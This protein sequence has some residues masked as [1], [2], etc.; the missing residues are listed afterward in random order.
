MTRLNETQT[1]AL[2]EQT[3]TIIEQ[4]TEGKSTRE[5][6]ATIYVDNL[7]NKTYEQG[8]MM[9][10]AIIES[11]SAF[12]TQYSDAKS[13]VDKWLDKELD[14]ITENM[15]LSEKCT[16]WI[17]IS[18]AVSMANEELRA[19]GTFNNEN[20][21]N[22][23][24]N[25]EISQEQA[26]TE[27]EKELYE[28][29]KEAIQNSN[30]ML[31]IIAE[32]GESLKNAEN[33]NSVAELLLDFGSR[34]IDFRA[35]ASMVAYTNVKNGTFDNISVDIKLDQLTTLVCA[36]VEEMRIAD[37]VAKEE[38][39]LETA[40]TLLSLLGMISAVCMFP[41]AIGIGALVVASFVKGFFILPTIGAMTVLMFIG[42]KKGF[43]WWKKETSELVDQ[44]A[45]T[46]K[47]LSESLETIKHSIK[48]TVVPKAISIIKSIWDKIEDV[49]SR[50]KEDDTAEVNEEETEDIE[51]EQNGDLDWIND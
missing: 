19:E 50:F 46:S 32:Q 25:L 51:L 24:E 17:K 33:E 4:A 42:F 34:E 47:S 2:L 6:M 36:T 27:L 13:D 23:I 40:K 48:E 21:L 20:I 18:T 37:A 1:K 14:N 38:M 28:K 39:E 30:V 26:T 15:S 45:V 12:D 22:E 7:D 5:I 29:A 8:L 16:L 31:S 35:I 10:D 11:V 49:I 44:C 43:A 3:Q 9:A 41:P